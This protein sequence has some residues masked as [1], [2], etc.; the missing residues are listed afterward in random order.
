MGIRHLPQRMSGVAAPNGG[1]VA[2]GF[3]II[4]ARLPSLLTLRPML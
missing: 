2:A 1:A 4:G 3:E